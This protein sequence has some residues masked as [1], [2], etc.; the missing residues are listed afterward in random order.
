MFSREPEQLK[1]FS[2]LPFDFTR[3]AE[4]YLGADHN[5]I[6]LPLSHPFEAAQP[7]PLTSA[8]LDGLY[9]TEF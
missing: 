2:L 5:T 4:R 9:V 1:G 6:A 7:S 8:T 3:H